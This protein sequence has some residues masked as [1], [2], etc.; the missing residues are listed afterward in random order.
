[1]KRQKEC[2]RISGKTEEFLAPRK[3]QT[4]G[5]KRFGLAEDLQVQ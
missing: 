3:M 1:M 4:S 5:M 2:S